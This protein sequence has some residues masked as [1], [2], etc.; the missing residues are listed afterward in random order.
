MRDRLLRL[1]VP[2]ALYFFVLN[3]LVAWIG[4]RQEGWP[5]GPGPMWFAEILLLFTLGYVAVRRALPRVGPLRIDVATT[6]ALALAMGAGSFLVRTQVPVNVWLPFPTIQPAHATQY[7]CLF[8]VGIAASRSDP[9]EQIAAQVSRYWRAVMLAATAAILVVF[10][11]MGGATGQANLDAFVGG[12]TWQS[13]AVSVWEQ[14]FAVGMIV[15]LLRGF[16]EAR[17]TAGPILSAAAASSYT[18][19]VFHPIVVVLLAVALRHLP[20]PSLAKFAI[21][22]PIAVLVM[23]AAARWVR[24][25]P[26]IRRVL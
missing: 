6:T 24:M 2:L 17:N 16:H 25:A 11:S 3:G 1:G 14:L 18:V 10:F 23:F 20:V 12:W 7:A 5:L 9:G 21:A 15:N 8:A 13:L 19:Y 4:G 26:L 22:A